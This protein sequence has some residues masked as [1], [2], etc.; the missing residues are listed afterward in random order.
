MKR[1]LFSLMLLVMQ[2]SRTVSE[3]SELL[4]H[5]SQPHIANMRVKMDWEKIPSGLVL[6][7]LMSSAD[8]KRY[9]VANVKSYQI[10]YE[11]K[12]ELVGKCLIRF[13][14][15][16]DVLCIKVGDV[17]IFGN[18]QDFP[19]RNFSARTIDGVEEKALLGKTIRMKGD[20]SGPLDKI[21]SYLF[22]DTGYELSFIDYLPEDQ[23]IDAELGGV[24]VDLALTAILHSYNYDYYIQ[25]ETI[26]IHHIDNW[27]DW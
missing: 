23:K 24:S 27:Q 25:D 2:L 5:L 21:I 16:Y 15:E 18:K 3:Y 22:K 10:N 26:F 6:A 12:S 20:Y 17:F 19:L 11:A 14:K 8:I 7:S 4:E 1:L 13:L 9:V